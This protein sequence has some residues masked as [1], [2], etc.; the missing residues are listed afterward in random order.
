MKLA[1]LSSYLSQAYVS[2]IGI[3]L[4]PI[5]LRYLGAEGVGLVGLHVMTVALLPLLDF[6]LSSVLSRDMSR[7]RAGA[8]SVDV[9]WARL[10][11][12]MRL[13]ALLA[14]ALVLVVVMFRHVLVAD[15][16]RLDMLAPEDA[17]Y[18]LMTI[19]IAAALRWLGGVYRAVLVGLEEQAR[20]N[21][22][23]L[24]LATIRHVGVVPV[25]AWYDPSATTFFSYQVLTGLLELLVWRHAVGMA[26]PSPRD[27]A[28]FRWSTG[29]RD[30]WS[31]AGGLTFLTVSWV[32]FNQAERLI[33]SRMLSL[34][35]FGCFSLVVS[36][37]GGILILM[38]PLTQVV[39]P[40]LTALFAEGR[41]DLV[42]DL[43]RAAT[44][45]AAALFATAGGW[46]AMFA[47]P[48]LFAWLGDAAIAREGAPILFWYGLANALAGLL[49][50][51]FMLQFASGDLRLHVLG[52]TVVVL[53]GLPLLVI[54]SIDYGAVGA[55]TVLCMLRLSFLLLWVPRIHRQF[56]PSGG[57]RWL[58]LDVA[59]IVIAVLGSL[60]IL[61]FLLPTES[62]RLA[63]GVSVIAAGGA[64]LVIGLLVGSM[65]RKTLQTWWVKVR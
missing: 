5:Y 59:P 41:L 54:A 55:G 17:E 34:P 62:S 30:A 23:A 2:L 18:C 49:S 43:Y 16:L 44:Q 9:A 46:L 25:L 15:W 51:P 64:A 39:Q 29:L 12:L 21:G 19:A 32:L 8:L 13:F 63:S 50:L 26:L 27:R 1:L 36:L 31:M 65:T 6:G 11:S 58:T 42:A 40:R 3:V 4:M 45:G 7:F 33:L 22:L 38:P 53:V 61:A 60:T 57:R 10:S 47:E 28:G 52:N 35:E 14:A 24:V 48:I 37:A 56:L 20:V